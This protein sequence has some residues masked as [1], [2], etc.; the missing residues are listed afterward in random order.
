MGY[1]AT[2]YAP[3]PGSSYSGMQGAGGWGGSG[4]GNT[5]NVYGGVGNTVSTYD[6]Q[7]ALTGPGMAGGLQ[8]GGYRGHAEAH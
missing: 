3:P 8:Y 2:P 4:V 5:A 7:T 6:S 1:N